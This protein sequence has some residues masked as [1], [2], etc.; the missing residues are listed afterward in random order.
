MKAHHLIVTELDDPADGGLYTCMDC[1]EHTE[2][3]PPDIPCPS[4]CGTPEQHMHL[5]PASSSR[6]ETPEESAAIVHE[7]LLRMGSRGLSAP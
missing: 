1:G 5:I 4:E 6:V 7:N 3:L 2:G